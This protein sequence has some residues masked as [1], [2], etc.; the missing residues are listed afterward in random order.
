MAPCASFRPLLA[1]SGN[2]PPQLT[3]TRE[4]A[5]APQLPAATELMRQDTSQSGTV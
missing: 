5:D 2:A 1:F 4:L 3:L